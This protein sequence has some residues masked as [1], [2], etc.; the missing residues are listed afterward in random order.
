METRGKLRKRRQDCIEE[1]GRQVE[2]SAA[3][4]RSGKKKKEEE[5]VGAVKCRGGLKANR[6]ELDT[7]PVKSPPATTSVWLM[8]FGQR[9]MG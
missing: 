6:T 2:F 1:D 3:S 8:D 4:D 7:P 9:R 5:S